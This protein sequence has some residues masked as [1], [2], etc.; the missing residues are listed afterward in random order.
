M[1]NN[2]K[3]GIGDLEKWTIWLSLTVGAVAVSYFWIDRPIALFVHSQ[4]QG[5]N[6]FEQLPH[7]PESRVKPDQVKPA[8]ACSGD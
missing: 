7:V 2:Q 1:W 3:R 5:V 8:L 6:L 4:L